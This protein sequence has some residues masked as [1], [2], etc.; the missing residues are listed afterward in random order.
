MKITYSN[1]ED[2]VGLPEVNIKNKVTAADMNEIKNVVNN[3]SDQIDDLQESLFKSNVPVG[4]ILQVNNLN[5]IPDN[6]MSC[7]G[8]A[9]NKIDYSSLYQA[10]GNTYGS[11]ADTFNLPNQ[12]KGSENIDP[13]LIPNYYYIIRVK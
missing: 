5:S 13:A 1:K 6:W 3:N 11:T 7:D 2:I 9:L 10:I 4:F 12:N 8:Q